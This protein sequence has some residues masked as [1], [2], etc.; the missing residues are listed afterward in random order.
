MSSSVRWPLFA[1]WIA[2]GTVAALPYPAAADPVPP[3]SA[4]LRETLSTAP[5]LAEARAGVAQAEGLRDQA[6]A[7]PNPRLSAELENFAPMG[8]SV[9]LPRAESRQSTFSVTQP[10]EFWG[11]RSARISAGDAGISA[12][13]AR[14]AQMET[15]YA[16]DLASAY[17]EAE[18][19]DRRLRLAQES[20]R[21]A[22]DDA[23]ITAA[24]VQA[25]REAEVR[26]LQAQTALATARASLDAAQSERERSLSSLTALTGSP[27]PY[28]E[29]PD[30]LLTHADNYE[31]PAMPDA[32]QSPIYKAAL[33]ARDEAERKIAVER[34]RA[35][36]DIDVSL[37]VR[38]FSGT[39][40]KA[41]VGSVSLPLPIFD[42]N[43]GNISAAEAEFRSASARLN[44][45][46]NEAAA[47]ARASVA[48]AKAALTRIAAALEAER[49]AE[50]V[51]RLTRAGYEGGKL[52][53]I[54]VLSSNRALSEAR[55]ATLEARL[56]RLAAEAALARLQGNVPFGDH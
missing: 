4:L 6:G 13:R 37:G 27:T 45:A 26:R 43:R 9:G 11:K 34:T 15:D 39:N 28:T 49:A 35:L 23:R 17:M 20:L 51:S 18:A 12:A 42:R 5:R 33:A 47:G 55:N 46:Q 40:A 24:L 31:L 44:A 54:E 3:F 32:L 19:D 14:L 21:F 29:I 16:F 50:Q 1:V 38:T 10:I 2:T 48:R 22:E 8:P 36:P 25:G 56:E 52:S 30:S 41:L 53:F 7:F